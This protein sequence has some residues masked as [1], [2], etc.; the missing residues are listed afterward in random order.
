M[1]DS[2]SVEV[3]CT[4]LDGNGAPMKVMR[5][6]IV[7][8]DATTPSEYTWEFYPGPDALRDAGL[9]ARWRIEVR[10]SPGVAEVEDPAVARWRAG[11]GR[12][13]E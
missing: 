2:E 11:V 5:F 13:H 4:L 8:F 3:V 1:P 9:F 10:R 6:P 12:T 7:L